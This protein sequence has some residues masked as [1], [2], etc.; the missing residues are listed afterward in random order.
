MSDDTYAHRVLQRVD[1][2][3]QRYYANADEDTRAAISNLSG[4]YRGLA[5][6]LAA[7]S[8]ELDHWAHAARDAEAE[9]DEALTRQQELEEKLEEFDEK[10]AALQDGLANGIA[11]ACGGGS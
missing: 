8:R 10:L 5:D 7:Q 4:I 9:R 3:V 1:A 11:A 6:A 2:L